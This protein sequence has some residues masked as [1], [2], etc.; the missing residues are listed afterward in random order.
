MSSEAADRSVLGNTRASSAAVT[1]EPAS[2]SPCS[3]T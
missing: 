1:P 2:S 3:T